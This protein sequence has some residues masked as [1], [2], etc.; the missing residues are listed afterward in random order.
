[1]GV[2]IAPTSP[3][4]F[5]S[6]EDANGKVISG[7]V[8]FSGAWN[9][10]NALTGGTFHRDAGCLY[11]KVILGTINTDGTFP[12]GTKVVDVSA[13]NGDKTFTPAQLATVGLT[14]VADIL[15]A[16]QITASP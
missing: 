15:N 13:V 8:T 5:Y 3:W 7:A 12:A 10:A 11:N 6:A 16:P 14:T 9:V 2:I 1:M 4:M